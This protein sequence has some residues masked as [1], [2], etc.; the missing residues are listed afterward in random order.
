LF[1]VLGTVGGAAL[2]L[3]DN[4]YLRKTKFYAHQKDTEEREDERDQRLAVL[5]AD[6]RAAQ[7]IRMELNETMKGV[8]AATRENT[9][10][11][12]KFATQLAVV[13]DRQNRDRH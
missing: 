8:Q 13:E 11:L 5:E 9:A 1:V 3:L 7:Q 12:N 2:W 4:F 6:V 10:A